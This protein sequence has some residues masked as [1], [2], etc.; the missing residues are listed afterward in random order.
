VEK[1]LYADLQ[2]AARESITAEGRAGMAIKSYEAI[3][4]LLKTGAAAASIPQVRDTKVV[5]E[6]TSE[7]VMKEGELAEML[8]QYGNQHPEVC[9]LAE[10]VQSVRASLSNECLQ[11][12]QSI[13]NEVELAKAQEEVHDAKR[14]DLEQRLLAWAMAK[15][16]IE[17]IH[18]IY[19]RVWIAPANITDASLSAQAL[20]AIARNGQVISAKIIQAS[21]NE[22]FDGTVKRALSTVKEGPPFRQEVREDTLRYKLRFNLKTQKSTD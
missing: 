19:D 18:T 14:I 11:I 22:D 7:L 10:H 9:R 15:A 17:N 16:D 21:G 12:I 8:K 2:A 6:L 5:Q 13:S 4:K 20:V 1:A 3:Q